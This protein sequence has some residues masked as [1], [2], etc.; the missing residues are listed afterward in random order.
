MSILTL[1]GI[2]HNFP[3]RFFY[4]LFSFTYLENKDSF[5]AL[6]VHRDTLEWL[7]YG[8][9]K[10]NLYSRY[11]CLFCLNICFLKYHL[12]NKK[13]DKDS[14]QDLL[15]SLSHWNFSKREGFHLRGC[16]VSDLTLWTRICTWATKLLKNY[17]Y[18]LFFVGSF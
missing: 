8:Q 2:N 13:D 9:Y 10:W 6:R 3:N 11:R 18:Y 16:Q 4:F 1:Q 14:Y 12:R 7:S 5:Y 15:G 17:S